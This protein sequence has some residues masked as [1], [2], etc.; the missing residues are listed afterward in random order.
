MS[1]IR[2]LARQVAAPILRLH[3]KLRGLKKKER[4]NLITLWLQGKNFIYP[5]DVT[6]VCFYFYAIV[7]LIILCLGHFGLL[8]AF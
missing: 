6:K 8:K 7:L 1:Q 3:Y 5:G 4:R 2:T